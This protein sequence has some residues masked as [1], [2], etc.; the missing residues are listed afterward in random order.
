MGLLAD[1]YRPS[2]ALLT[3]LYQLTMAYAVWRSGAWKDEAVFHLNFRRAPFASGYTVAA[4]LPAALE[5]LEGLRFTEEDRAYLATLSGA[6]GKPL[7]EPAFLD[8]LGRLDLGLDVDAVPEGTLVFPQEP[9]LRVKGPVAACMLAETPLLNLVNF[10]TLVA[11]KAARVVQA[12][13]G[14]PVLEFG[15]RRAQGVDG[16]M[17]ASRAA[18]LGGC[19][20]TSNVLAGRLYG[21]PVKG[22]HAH[23]WVMLFDEERESFQRY[24]EAMPNNCVFLVDTYDT[25][26][27]VR[28]AVE[29]GRWLRARGQTLLGV[30]LDSGD[31]ADLS[32]KARQILDEGGFPEARIYASNDLD[33]KIIESLKQQDARIAVWGVGTR[34]VTAFDEPALG[35]VYKLAAVRAQGAKEWR[36]R[37]KVSEQPAKTSTPGLLQVRRFETAQGFAGDGIYN[38][39]AG[40][41]G[42]R[43]IIHPFDPTLR[44]PIPAGASETD[45]LVPAMRA[46]KIVLEGESLEGARRR[47]A[48]QLERL[49][50][51]AKRFMN[52][53]LYPVGLEPRLQELRTKMVLEARKVPTP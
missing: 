49:P 17:T 43:E 18:Y 19:A 40:W 14:E 1:L 25:L 31:L 23:S 48:R 29:V 5:L 12:A 34:L 42:P 24:A 21:I 16:A 37:V 3:D 2:L 30:R 46:G 9:L 6:D 35:G 7:F 26:Q 11:T 53:H 44:W 13:R 52:A 36:Y 28:H 33:E 27:G 41:Q 22:T 32:I 39:D 38:L 51:G 15:L 50:A 45:L 47:V 20:A 10:P 8:A 4:G